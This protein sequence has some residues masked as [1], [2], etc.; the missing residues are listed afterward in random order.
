MATVK[1]EGMESHWFRVYKGVRQEC[2]LSPWLFNVFIDNA[3]KEAGGELV[4]QV[5]WSTGTIGVL[6]FADDMV[7]MAK[8]TTEECSTI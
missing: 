3:V 8:I 1:V 4:R 5:R 7:L 2:T 6:L